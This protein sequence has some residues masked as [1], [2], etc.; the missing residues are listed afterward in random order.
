MVSAMTTKTRTTSGA[1]RAGWVGAI[2]VAGAT[3][4]P[5][6][7]GSLLPAASFR[8]DNINNA[9][10]PDHLPWATEGGCFGTF[11]MTTASFLCACRD[12]RM[13]FSRDWLCPAKI[14]RPFVDSDNGLRVQV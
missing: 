10:R 13:C 3:L 7:L 8:R 4:Q 5:A 2:S 12:T 9:N 1:E 14:I 11:C 6:F